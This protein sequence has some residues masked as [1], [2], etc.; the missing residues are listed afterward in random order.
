M[1]TQIVLGNNGDSMISVVKMTIVIVMV[2][3]YVD[4]SVVI[5][6]YVDVFIHSNYHQLLGN[7]QWSYLS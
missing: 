1:Y 6:T 7:F 3:Y 4:T 2:F 5:L